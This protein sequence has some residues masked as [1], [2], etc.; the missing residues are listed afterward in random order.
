[1]N[2]AALILVA[3]LA[4]GQPG[5][6]KGTGTVV[7]IDRDMGRVTIEVDPIAALKLPELALAFNVYSE[8]VW[9]RVHRGDHVEFEFAKQGNNFVLLRVLNKPN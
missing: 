3:A 5:T 8:R 4:F 9:N 1:M 7:A 2:A 6:Y